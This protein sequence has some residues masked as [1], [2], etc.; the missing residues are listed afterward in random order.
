MIEV[1]MGRFSEPGPAAGKY[2]GIYFLSKDTEY[3]RDFIEKNKDREWA[4]RW[5]IDEGPLKPLRKSLDRSGYIIYQSDHK[6]TVN[7]G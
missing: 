4:V 1:A 7:N 5:E 3:V 2:S 6:I